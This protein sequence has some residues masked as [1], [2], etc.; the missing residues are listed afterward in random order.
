MNPLLMTNRVLTALKAIRRYEMPDGV[1]SV[2]RLHVCPG[3]GEISGYDT[4]EIGIMELV[5]RASLVDVGSLV[6]CP[7]CSM[8][9]IR[10]KELYDAVLR[11]TGGPID[12]VAL[13]SIRAMTSGSS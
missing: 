7:S 11:M 3:C 5:T 13:D 10:D 2:R 9:E 8:L 6:Q 4:V 12:S 1:V